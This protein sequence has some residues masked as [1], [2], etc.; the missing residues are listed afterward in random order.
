MKSHPIQTNERWHKIQIKAHQTKLILTKADLNK[1][2]PNDSRP[3]PYH[4]KKID[5]RQNITNQTIKLQQ[6]T[7]KPHQTKPIPTSLDGNEI[8]QNGSGLNHTQM[9][10][11]DYHQKSITK[12]NPLL[13]NQTWIKPTQMILYHVTP[14]VHKYID[15]RQI[16][17]TTPNHTQIQPNQTWI[18]STQMNPNQIIS[19][20][21]KKEKSITSKNT[22]YTKPLQITPKHTVSTYQI[23][24]TYPKPLNITRTFLLQKSIQVGSAH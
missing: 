19:N 4:T 22:N 10:K 12:P 18:K 7:S 11:N 8:T 16:T 9:T 3:H 14:K 20:H 5:Y 23:W 15:Y 24:I 21:T 13:S 17:Q 6:I 1:I 2:T